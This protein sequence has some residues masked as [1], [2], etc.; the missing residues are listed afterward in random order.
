MTTKRN[1]TNAR[2]WRDYQNRPVRATKQVTPEELAKRLKRADEVIED[3]IKDL[4]G[5]SYGYIGNV[6]ND[7]RPNPDDRSWFIFLPHSDRIGTAADRIGGYSTEE[8][9]KL[10]RDAHALSVGY[11]LEGKA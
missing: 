6:W 2:A 10:G 8:R 5:V 1:F 7:G 3:L 4:A 9:Y 11:N